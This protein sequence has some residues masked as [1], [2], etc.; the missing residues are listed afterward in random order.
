MMSAPTTIRAPPR[1]MCA[2]EFFTT[3]QR[4]KTD[5]VNTSKRTRIAALPGAVVSSPTKIE[6]IKQNAEKNRDEKA[7]FPH[8]PVP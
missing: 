7:V 4:E 5:V 6:S 1:G 3:E 8:N 2:W